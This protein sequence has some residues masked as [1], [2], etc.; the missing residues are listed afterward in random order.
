MV[1]PLNEHLIDFLV[2]KTHAKCL[3]LVVVDEG[4]GA[5][6]FVAANIIYPNKKKLANYHYLLQFRY[7]GL[8]Q[9]LVIYK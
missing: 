4:S 5:G 8:C 3:V 6:D 7:I 2:T 1:V 9:S